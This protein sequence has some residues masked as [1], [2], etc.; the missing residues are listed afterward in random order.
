[1]SDEVLLS[2]CSLLRIFKLLSFQNLHRTLSL[3]LTSIIVTE[4]LIGP[5]REVLLLC[6]LCLYWC[7]LQVELFIS[8]IVSLPYT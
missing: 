2:I 4:L 7:C 3:E 6:T 8:S 1:M 5:S